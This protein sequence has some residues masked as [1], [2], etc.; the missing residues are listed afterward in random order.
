MQDQKAGGKEDLAWQGVTFS[1][2]VCHSKYT[3]ESTSDHPQWHK[4]S[5]PNSVTDFIIDCDIIQWVSYFGHNYSS[6]FLFWIPIILLGVGTSEHHSLQ[7]LW[8]LGVPRG[9]WQ[10]GRR[11]GLLRPGG[12]G[13]RPRE[14]LH[15]Q[16]YSECGVGPG[17]QA[18]SDRGAGSQNASQGTQWWNT[19]E[20]DSTVS[21]TFYQPVEL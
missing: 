7:Q 2:F 19:D 3:V 9:L 21:I 18:L 8:L 13:L 6:F 20:Q 10:L 14:Q 12:G 17:W 5:D 16:L 1:F 11:R 4:C 15:G